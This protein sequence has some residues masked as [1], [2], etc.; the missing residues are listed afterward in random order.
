MELMTSEKPKHSALRQ[1]G[2]SIQR[3]QRNERN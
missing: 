3:T 1:P 2:V